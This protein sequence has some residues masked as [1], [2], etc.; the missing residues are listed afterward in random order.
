MADT[1]ISN[2]PSASALDGNEIVPILQ[3]G[4]NKKTY[5]STILTFF[6]TLLVKGDV[7]LG[8]VDNTSDANKPVSTAQATAD[9][10]VLTAAKGYT[11]DAIA[12]EV[13]D[14]NTAI[15]A[16]VDSSPATLDTLNELAAALG[17]DPNYAASTAT[18]IGLR[19]LL[20]NKSTDVNTDQAS[21][22]KYP[23]VKSVFDWATGLFQTLLNKDASGGYAGLTLFKINFK[24]AANT[25]TSFFTNLNTA[26]RTYTFQDRDGIIADDTD[27]ALKASLASPIFTGTPSLPTGTIA[28]TQSQGDNSN[29]PATTAYVDGSLASPAAKLFMYNNFI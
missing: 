4:A 29:K 8:N 1:K 14:R 18:A 28:V 13:I 16:L 24:N 5:L 19:E 20:S 26:A 3:S 6:K 12:Q 15:A 2:D 11:D 10:A 25:F 7:G 21:N 22:V 17:D 27:L 23:S 9:A